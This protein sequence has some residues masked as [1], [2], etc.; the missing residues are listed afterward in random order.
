MWS[1]RSFQCLMYSESGVILI[2]YG[3][4]DHPRGNSQHLRMKP[5]L[6]CLFQ[7][8]H[9]K[10]Y[11]MTLTDKNAARCKSKLE[12]ATFPYGFNFL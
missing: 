3:F 6:H 11:L 10:M 1:I 9:F 7:H 8:L 5:R 4:I 12:M 2:T